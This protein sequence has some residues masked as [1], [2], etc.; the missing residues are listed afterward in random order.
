MKTLDLAFYDWCDTLSLQGLDP[1][2]MVRVRSQCRPVWDACRKACADLCIQR[3]E[4]GMA[5]RIMANEDDK[6]GDSCYG[7]G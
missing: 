2:A 6:H 1:I 4:V 5:R 7:D 3:D